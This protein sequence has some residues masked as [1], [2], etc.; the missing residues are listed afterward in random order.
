VSFKP[1]FDVD[2]RIHVSESKVHWPAEGVASYGQSV[3]RD[4]TDL[5]SATWKQVGNTLK[6]EEALV[7]ECTSASSDGALWKDCFRVAESDFADDDSGLPTFL[8]LGTAAAT[9][10]LNAAG[11][12]TI[13]SCNGHQTGYPYIA[14]WGR[15]K[16]V[17]LIQEAAEAAG[18]GFVNGLNG[19][20]EVFSDAPD[21]LIR[22]AGELHKRSASFRALR[23][24][25]SKRPK[26]DIQMAFGLSPKNSTTD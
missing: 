16:H 21:G 13:M 24:L 14:F 5:R 10:A 3:N 25:R 6:V 1:K 22:L 17:V 9:I 15:K 7:S 20:L 4:Y 23:K 19:A 12:S 2:V 26:P 18:V 8:D 11:C